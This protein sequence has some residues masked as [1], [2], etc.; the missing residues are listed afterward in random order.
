M[1]KAIRKQ[2]RKIEEL[3]GTVD[4]LLKAVER[5]KDM[6]PPT[7]LV[8]EELSKVQLKLIADMRDLTRAIDK[9]GTRHTERLFDQ[10]KMFIERLLWR[11]RCGRSWMMR[12]GNMLSSARSLM[13]S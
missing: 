4:S 9:I 1:R 3:Q 13:L 10:E 7:I 6:P 5:G 8:T 12:G 2:Q 11:H